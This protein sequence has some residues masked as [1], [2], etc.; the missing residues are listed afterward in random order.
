MSRFDCNLYVSIH[1]V[2]SIAWS[3][4]ARA[5][6]RD[7]ALSGERTTRQARVPRY[8]RCTAIG[9]R[10]RHSVSQMRAPHTQRLSIVL[11]YSG[12]YSK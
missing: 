10:A 3:I 2:V 4:E 8:R 11:Q 1:G 9:A 5:L 7:S 12:V 6:P